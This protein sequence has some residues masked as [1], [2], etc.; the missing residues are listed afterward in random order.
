MPTRN[1]QQEPVAPEN[2]S[3]AAKAVEGTKR[4]GAY[5]EE[6]AEQATKAVGTGMESLGGAIHEHEPAEGTLHNIGEAVADKLEGGGRYLEAR[7]LKGIGEDL[8]NVIR[9]N[10][11]PALL[12]GLGVGVLLAHLVK[13]S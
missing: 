4:L 10:P 9:Q 12:V 3:V 1:H 2:A 6:K 13:R 7:G 11:I 8:T 5:M